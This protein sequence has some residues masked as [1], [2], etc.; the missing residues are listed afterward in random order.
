MSTEWKMQGEYLESC[1][2]RGAC[3]CI[4]LEP[5]TEG[6]CTAMVGW[7]IKNGHYG[8]VTLDN[9]NIAV[10]LNAPGPMAEGNW[11]AVLY[12]DERADEQQQEALGAVF[13][14]KAGGH[15]E[16]LASM[17]G[18]VLAVEKHP[19][20]FVIEKG[21]RHLTIGES[22]E[23][24]INAIEGQDGRDVTINAHPFAVA[25]GHSLV[26]AKSRSLRH[27][28]HGLQMNLSGRTAL[29]SPFEYTGP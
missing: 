8:E 2:C 13:G 18:E 24:R 6:D 4:Y 19:I 28:S 15:P 5:P 17:I 16:I 9:L 29:Y 14:G 25:P 22:H 21:H 12:I 7:H 3:P 26:V 27:Q 1:T 10:V 23:A 11:K 20:G